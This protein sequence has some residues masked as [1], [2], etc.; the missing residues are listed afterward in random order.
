[1][2]L[3]VG[4]VDRLN[5]APERLRAIFEYPDD[6][7]LRQVAAQLLSDTPQAASVVTS[8][9]Q[10]LSG[11]PRLTRESFREVAQ[12]VRQQTGVKGRSL[13]HSIRVALTGLGSGPEFDLLLP[14]IDAGA[15]AGNGLRPIIGCRERAARFHQAVVAVGGATPGP[16]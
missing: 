9:A 13:F 8:L 3:V 15:E 4:A 10:A 11:H 2:P 1:L 6:G 12:I 7:A 5:D 16:A 14:A